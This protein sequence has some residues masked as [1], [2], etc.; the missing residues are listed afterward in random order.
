MLEYILAGLV[1]GSIYAIA[2]ASITITFVSTGILNFAF[3]SFAFFLART[4][5][6]LNTQHGWP[7]I[8]SAVV[9]LLVIAPAMA[10]FLYVVLLRHLSRC[11]RLVQIVATIGL[12]VALPPVASVL[13]GNLTIN[14]APGLAPVPV[15]VFHPLGLAVSLDQVITFAF[16]LGI[17][18]FG[19]LL[20]RFTDVGLRVRGLVSSRAL[21]S[22]S[23]INSGAVSLSVWMISTAL[24]GLAGILAAPSSGL[25]TQ[26]MTELMAAVFAAVIAARLSSLPIAVTVALLMGIG[27]DLIQEYLPANGSFAAAVVPSA[28]FVVTALAFVYFYI[29]RRS[30]RDIGRGGSLDAAIAPQSG[31]SAAP[32]ADK[33]QRAGRAVLSESVFSIGSVGSVVAVAVIACLPLIFSGYWLTLIVGGF[34]YGVV[35]LSYTLAL[36]E[37]G[38]LW[39]SLISFTG[40]GAIISA[41]FA[42]VA[43]WPPFAAV[44]VAAVIVTPVGVLLGLLTSR[45]GELYIA[46]ATLT[47]GLLVETLVFTSNRFFQNGVGVPMSVPG[48]ATG[49]RAFGYLALA[50][51]VVIALFLVNI[52]RSTTGLALSAAR[53][54]EAASASV[55]GLSVMKLRV[56][57]CAMSTFVAALGG[58]LLAMYN[59]LALPSSYSTFAGLIFIAV[60]VTIGVRSIVAAVVAGIAFTIGPGLVEAYL[61]AGW[62]NL[63]T[64]MFGLGAIGLTIDPDGVV[65]QAAR[66]CE[67]LIRRLRKRGR[68]PGSSTSGPRPADKRGEADAGLNKLAGAAQAGDS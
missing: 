19:T 1:L 27:T 2:A 43:G 7:I 50:I 11:S 62:G 61:P 47:F 12:F 33:A 30:L 45:F 31:A 44:L 21:A 36:G 55:L 49:E 5:Y 56:L 42:T 64:I 46:L 26:G 65:T 32:R 37:G 51:F 63:P 25:T 24:A 28:P 53:S 60:L 54:S 29:R 35:F 20:L 57:V 18:A 38:F 23:G 34:V 66:Q 41:Q 48:W 8:P 39:L 3:G 10:A 9:T 59:L 4:Y 16:L 22:L 14:S 58:G 67:T 13:Y 68:T 52:R 6:W 15:R 17:L 40:L